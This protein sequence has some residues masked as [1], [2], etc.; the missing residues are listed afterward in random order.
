MF[1][2]AGVLAFLALICF[3]LSAF[4]VPNPVRLNSIGGILLSV[5]MLWGS[6]H[7]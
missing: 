2:I 1:S 7:A 4:G 6:F 5:A 3:A